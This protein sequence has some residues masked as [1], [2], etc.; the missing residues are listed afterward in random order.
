M[1]LH[2]FL[3]I[4]LSSCRQ[5]NSKVDNTVNTVVLHSGAELIKVTHIKLDI[6][7]WQILNL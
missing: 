1:Y 3:N 7:T 6:T 5:Y 4:F 2:C